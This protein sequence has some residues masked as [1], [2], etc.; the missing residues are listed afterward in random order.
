MWNSGLT[1]GANFDF[2]TGGYLKVGNL[3]VVALSLN[4]KSD[5]AETS[6]VDAVFD[7]PLPIVEAALG[8][9]HKSILIHDSCISFIRAKTFEYNKQTSLLAGL[10]ILSVSGTMGVNYEAYMSYSYFIFAPLFLA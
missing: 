5:I 2:K 4:I 7:L 1:Y 6:Y 3:V 10:K 9:A 8:I